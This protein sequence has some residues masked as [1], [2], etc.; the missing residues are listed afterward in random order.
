MS[1]KNL[2]WE[3][4]YRPQVVA[5]VILPAQ[6]RKAIEDIM[7]RGNIPNF[8]FYGTAGIGKTTLASA[9]ATETGADLLF[10]NASL[11][12]NIDTLRT[13][14]TQFVSTVSLSDSDTKK[15]VLLDE[16]DYLNAQSTQP[17]L[18]GFIDEFS[19]NAIFI[20]TCNYKERLIEPLRDSRMTPLEFKFTKEDKQAAAMQMLKRACFI[21]EKEGIAYDKKVVAGLITKCFPDFRKTL[22]ALQFYSASGTIDSGILVS[23]DVTRLDELSALIKEKA[24]IKCRQWIANN[25]IDAQTFYRG[26]YDRLLPLLVPTSV[27]QII[28]IIADRQQQSISSVDQEINQVAALIEIMQ[29]SVFK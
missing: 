16:A 8:V 3:Q 15:I 7:A 12:G 17:A 11:S 4:K 6:T 22:N 26:L 24:F 14:I 21:L 5:D 20:L 29:A 27:P 1:L 23:S 13:E 9:I 10:I 19:S 28:L 25:Q 2:V 18:R